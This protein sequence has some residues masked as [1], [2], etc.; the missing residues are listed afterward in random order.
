MF[1]CRRQKVSRLFDCRRL[2]GAVA[3]LAG[4]ALIQKRVLSIEDGRYAALN[5]FG[6]VALIYSLLFG[7][8][9]GSFL[10]QIAWL[11]FTVVGYIHSRRQRR[12][13]VNEPAV[14]QAVANDDPLPQVEVAG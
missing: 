12:K 4:Y 1:P 5:V 14:I 3:Y 13:S 7:F 9:L 2:V 10:S 11:I 8:N 6:G